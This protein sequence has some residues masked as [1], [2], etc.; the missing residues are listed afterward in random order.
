MDSKIPTLRR[1]L[2]TTAFPAHARML[3]SPD[4]RHAPQAKNRTGPPMF[5]CIKPRTVSGSN[6]AKPADCPELASTQDR[7]K[8]A[9]ARMPITHGNFARKRF[10]LNR[11]TPKGT[12]TSTLARLKLDST[13][14]RASG[15]LSA[16][17]Y[18]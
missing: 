11:M 6:Q 17:K 18:A 9:P 2:I 8:H 3:R 13:E 15:S 7:I 4:Q 16:E 10:S 5:S 1:D 14:I 12:V